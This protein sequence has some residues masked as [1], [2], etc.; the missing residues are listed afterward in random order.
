MWPAMTGST[1]TTQRAPIRAFAMS[2]PPASSTGAESE[3]HN[4]LSSMSLFSSAERSSAGRCGPTRTGHHFQQQARARAPAVEVRQSRFLVL[5]PPPRKGGSAI[6][7][8]RRGRCWLAVSNRFAFLSD[9]RAGW[10]STQHR[11]GRCVP[12]RVRGQQMLSD[13][14]SG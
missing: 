12:A 1:P 9:R 4:A 5:S 7:G 3:G 13:F 11:W 2:A 6:W 10:M 14:C 8:G